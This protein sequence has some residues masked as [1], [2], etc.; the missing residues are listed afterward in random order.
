M[1]PWISLRAASDR[2]SSAKNPAMT[3]RRS[4]RGLGEFE[5]IERYF[6]PLATS[7]AALGLRDDVALLRVPPRHELVVSADAIV[8]GVHFFPS[9][10]PATVAQKALRM[11]LSDLAAK[12]AKPLG[13]ML[14]LALPAGRRSLWLKWFA[15][16]LAR[17]QRQ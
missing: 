17:D 9:D 7:P 12:G 4:K 5:L 10:P 15:S 14:T 6:S 11:N 13:Y 3:R 1:P 2:W 16:G 8:E